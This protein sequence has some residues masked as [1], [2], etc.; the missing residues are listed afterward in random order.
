MCDNIKI[1][2]D[3][4][5]HGELSPEDKN[6]VEA[7][8]K[9]CANCAEFFESEKKYY[10]ELKLA[11][12]EPEISIAGA[13]MDKIINERIIVDKPAKKRFVPFGLISAAVIVLVMFI[14]SRDALDLFGNIYD[15]TELGVANYADDVAYPEFQISPFGI[16]RSGAGLEFNADNENIY[17]I[18]S[19][20]S[21]EALLEFKEELVMPAE[22][23]RM[24][25]GEIIR[26]RRGAIDWDFEYADGFIF[27]SA[28][29][30]AIFIEELAKLGLEYEIENTGI[31]SEYIKIIYI[32]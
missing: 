13:V 24:M 9:S 25:T 28:A 10:K 1:L 6:I 15:D 4:Y 16:E 20:I 19:I 31:E 32:D 14:A 29:D 12:H 18:E 3:E 2:A 22:V 23:N 17:G 5:F 27:I 11:A 30:R 7:H 8:I 21:D 26:I